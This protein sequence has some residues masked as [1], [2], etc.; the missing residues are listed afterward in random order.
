LGRVSTDIAVGMGLGSGSLLQARES[1]AVCPQRAK[2]RRRHV[3]L[4][5]VCGRNGRPGICVVTIMK[6]NVPWPPPIGKL[7][8]C[9]KCESA[10]QAMSWI[11]LAQGVFLLA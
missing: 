9:R 11:D 3:A 5:M 1:D 7:R 8:W 4:N 6:G 2:K 10:L